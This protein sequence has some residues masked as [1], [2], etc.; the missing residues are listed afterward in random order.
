M[1][2]INKFEQ[3]K[4]IIQHKQQSIKNK[5]FLLVHEEFTKL[6]WYLAENEFNHIVYEKE[7]H[8]C[9]NFTVDIFDN[10]IKVNVPIINTNYSYSTKFAEYFRA[11]EFLLMHLYAIN[12]NIKEKKNKKH[13]SDNDNSNEN[14]EQ[15]DN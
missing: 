15:T 1:N 13:L 2:F 6:G 3:A 8:Q 11:Q 12:E 10:H 14:N 5:G 7:G 4:D 9:D